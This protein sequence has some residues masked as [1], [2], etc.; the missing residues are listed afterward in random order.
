MTRGGSTIRNSEQGAVE[1]RRK[2]RAH[3]PACRGAKQWKSC[4][5][6]CDSIL[7]NGYGPKRR[8]H[9][10]PS[11]PYYLRVYGTATYVLHLYDQSGERSGS[12]F[13][14]PTSPAAGG[15]GR[16]PTSPTDP[17]PNWTVITAAE[18][19]ERHRQFLP[20][21]GPSGC[22]CRFYMHN[23]A[24]HSVL[25]YVDRLPDSPSITL[26]QLKQP[27]ILH[28]RLS[29]TLFGLVTFSRARTDVRSHPYYTR[30]PCPRSTCEAISAEHGASKN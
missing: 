5:D 24:S 6:S 17:T 27:P 30:P 3:V 28:T 11:S 29:C 1:T 23:V 10:K 16:S 18:N 14:Q 19:R 21:A 13:V 9:N 7:M 26:L 8:N 4:F 25:S 2:P 22:S 20:Y 12:T 15:F